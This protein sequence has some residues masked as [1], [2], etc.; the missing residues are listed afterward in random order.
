MGRAIAAILG[1][2]EPAHWIFSRP[3]DGCGRTIAAF[4]QELTRDA[5][6]SYRPEKHYMRGPGPAC[7]AKYGQ[8]IKPQG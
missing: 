4:W 6:S 3:L 2:A 1:S 5:V 8:V 7:Q